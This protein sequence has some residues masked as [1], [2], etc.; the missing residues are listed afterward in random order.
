MILKKKDA[1]KKIGEIL[2]NKFKVKIRL[3]SFAISDSLIAALDLKKKTIKKY[4]R[5][6]K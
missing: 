3:R 6:L 1:S 5:I 2:E 4:E